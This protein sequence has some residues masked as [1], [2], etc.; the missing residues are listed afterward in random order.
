MANA[1][2]PG[3]PARPR[4]RKYALVFLGLAVVVLGVVFGYRRLIPSLQGHEVA[5][6]DWGQLPETDNPVKLEDSPV[7]TFG[8]QYD[9]DLSLRTSQETGNY[10]RTSQE[11]GNYSTN[12]LAIERYVRSLGVI[13][14]KLTLGGQPVPIPEGRSQVASDPAVTGYR[15]ST[16]GRGYEV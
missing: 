15:L 5:K 11:T 2:T 16:D 4:S 12:Q 9:T 7:R 10:S 6:P 3:T 1:L 8:V 13:P 14:P